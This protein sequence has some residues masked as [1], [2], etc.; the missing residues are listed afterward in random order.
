MSN[1]SSNKKAQHYKEHGGYSEL[2]ALP[3]GVRDPFISSNALLIHLRTQGTC[4][5]VFEK[6]GDHNNKANEIKASASLKGL[7]KED[8]DS[9]TWVFVEHL[10]TRMMA[11]L[12]SRER[13]YKEY[14]LFIFYSAAKCGYDHCQTQKV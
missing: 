1:S 2:T 10:F 14:I 3:K 7:N 4:T 12:V 8:F 13:L 5:T 6:F 11:W 9:V